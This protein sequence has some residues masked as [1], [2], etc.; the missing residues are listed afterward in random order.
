MLFYHIRHLGLVFLNNN[1][2][3]VVNNL[4]PCYGAHYNILETIGSQN[5]FD[6]IAPVDVIDASFESHDFIF[7]IRTVN[8]VGWGRHCTCNYYQLTA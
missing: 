3:Q 2:L 6:L 7:L 8:H 4:R 5:E 1:G